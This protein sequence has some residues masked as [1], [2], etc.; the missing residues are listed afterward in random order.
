MKPAS[1]VISSRLI[2][3]LSVGHHRSDVTSVLFFIAVYSA[4]ATF[5]V[6]VSAIMNT[7]ESILLALRFNRLPS[8]S[9]LFASRSY[10]G[11][12]VP[13]LQVNGSFSF[14]LKLK[15]HAHAISC[16]Y[17]GHSKE[18]H[19]HRVMHPRLYPYL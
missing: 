8:V 4:T 1:S 2:N 7:I 17:R 10:V 18:F 11:V 6:I 9:G 14:F 16:Q 15:N 19:I 13:C 3:L 12:D 5:L